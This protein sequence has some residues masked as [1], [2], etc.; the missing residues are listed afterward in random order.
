MAVNRPMYMELK[1]AIPV[2]AKRGTELRAKT[3]EAEAALRMLE[4]NL[5]PENALIPD[6]L[7]VYGGAGRAA[8]NWKE[9]H[10]IVNA[11][12]NL[13]PDETLLIQSGKPVGIIRTYRNSPRVLIANSNIVPA[14]S[15]QENFDKY[16]ALGL[17]MYGQMTAGSWIYIGTQGILQGTFQTL[18][19]IADKYYGGTLA[20]KWVV[21][22]G[23]GG[24]SGAQPL[25]VTMNEG[26]IINVEADP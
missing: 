26:V 7:I 24:M 22:G 23:L 18:A 21:T 19:A 20:G 2:R 5:D 6:Q 16:D 11:L 25:S 15:T 4:N 13:E 3:W 8:R 14:W 12:I 9:Y 10:K 1:P 17:T